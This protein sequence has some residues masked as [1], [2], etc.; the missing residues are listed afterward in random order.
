MR[1]HVHLPDR[2]EANRVK[3]ADRNPGIRPDR[4]RF[5]RCQWCGYTKDLFT[6]NHC[7]NEMCMRCWQDNDMVCQRCHRKNY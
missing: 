4:K 1:Y 7:S 6:C 5:D 3:R 2:D